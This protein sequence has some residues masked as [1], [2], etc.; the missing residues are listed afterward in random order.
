MSEQKIMTCCFCGRTLS[1]MERNSTFPITENNAP[2]CDVCDEL[3]VR[4]MRRIL[5]RSTNT[6]SGAGKSMQELYRAYPSYHALVGNLRDA[7]ISVQRRY[8]RDDGLAYKHDIGLVGQTLRSAIGDTKKVFTAIG[9]KP[10]I[11]EDDNILLYA[12]YK[13]YSLC[14]PIEEYDE[15][16]EFMSSKEQMTFAR[17]ASKRAF[18]CV[19]TGM[20][21]EQGLEFLVSRKQAMAAE[22]HAHWFSDDETMKVKDGESYEAL[23]TSVNV[24]AARIE[25]FGAEA[26]LPINHLTKN[27]TIH[28]ARKLVKVGDKISVRVS[29]IALDVGLDTVSFEA[30]KNEKFEEYFK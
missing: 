5:T 11:D 1:E 10:A 25:L 9:F 6:K 21:S 3:V 19:V 27:K 16:C 15:Q 23:V 24:V 17:K 14:M 7:S 26:E 8:R 12:Q 22:R 30:F 20:A 29:N 28:D 13:G 18:S 4:V 2:C